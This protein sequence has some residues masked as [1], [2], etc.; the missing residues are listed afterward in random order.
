MS[1]SKNQYRILEKDGSYGFIST[2]RARHCLSMGL[3]VTVRK[4]V[5]QFVPEPDAPKVCPRPLW[6]AA[7]EVIPASATDSGQSGFLRYPPPAF[8]STRFGMRFPTLSKLGAGL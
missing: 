5:I 2:S 1:K 8:N 6:G 7:L 3:A 4:G